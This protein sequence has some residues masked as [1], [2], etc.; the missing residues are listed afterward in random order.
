MSPL[1]GLLSMRPVV[2]WQTLVNELL[3]IEL[4]LLLLLLLSLLL[5]NYGFNLQLLV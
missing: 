2:S 4:S 3:E 1:N 5:L